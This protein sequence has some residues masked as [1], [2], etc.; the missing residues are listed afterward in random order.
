MVVCP[1][2]ALLG[3]VAARSE[4]QL[5]RCEQRREV[6]RHEELD[7]GCCHFV[8]RHAC[9]SFACRGENQTFL[10][11][12]NSSRSIFSLLLVFVYTRM[13]MAAMEQ[14]T[15]LTSSCYVLLSSLPAAPSH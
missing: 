3:R 2:S 10:C 13:S 4:L 5:A 1:E 15:I 9:Y 11:L 8:C 7:H 6:K 14:C 12:K